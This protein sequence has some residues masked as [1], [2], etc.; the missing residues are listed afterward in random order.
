MRAGLVR[1]PG[2]PGGNIVIDKVE[3]IKPVLVVGVGPGHEDYLTRAAE[4]AIKSSGAWVGGA[5]ALS[6]ADRVAGVLPAPIPFY[7]IGSDLGGTVKFIVENRDQ[8]VAVLVTGD[9]GFYSMLGFLRRHF[10]PG[11]LEVI[12]GISS[13][14]LAFAR[15]SRPWQDA[16]LLTLHGRGREAVRAALERALKETEKDGRPLA[17]LTDPG[18]GPRSLAQWLVELG[19]GKLTMTVCRDLSEAGEEIISSTVS[20][21]ASGPNPLGAAVVVLDRG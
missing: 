12:P 8:G 13:M 16:R 7:R 14:Q 15:L 1:L 2:K 18:F 9:P 10:E 6:L 21:I 20:E 11:D 19:R 17:M 5:R 3:K 4:R